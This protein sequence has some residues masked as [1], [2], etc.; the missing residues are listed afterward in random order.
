[1]QLMFKCSL[2]D[3]NLL[4]VITRGSCSFKAIASKHSAAADIP[5]MMKATL[6]A[7]TASAVFPAPNI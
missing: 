7:T 5:A 3:T 6:L 2:H 1:M 4:F